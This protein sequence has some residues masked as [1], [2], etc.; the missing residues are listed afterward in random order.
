MLLALALAGCPADP[1]PPGGG[2]TTPVTTATTAT[3]ASGSTPA[4]PL[5][6]GVFS[7]DEVLELFRAEHAAGARPSKETEA[8]RLRAF[9]KHRLVDD[10]GREVAARMRAYERAVQALAEDVDAWSEFVDSL[11]RP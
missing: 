7:R 4:D 6:G 8:A 5:A 2:G 3:P 11:E 1:G 10:E 9:K